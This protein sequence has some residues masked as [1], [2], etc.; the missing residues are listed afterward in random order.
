MTSHEHLLNSTLKSEL[1][2]Y[3]TKRSAGPAAFTFTD[4]TTGD[5]GSLFAL[6]HADSKAPS[7]TAI[8]VVP[9]SGLTQD[10]QMQLNDVMMLTSFISVAS[11]RQLYNTIYKSAP[12]DITT[13]AG[14]ALFVQSAANAKTFVLTKALGGYLSL[15]TSA[16]RAFSQ[17]TTSADLHLDFLNTLFNG[18]NFPKSTIDELDGVLT[19]VTQTIGNL[20]MSWSDQSS[21]LDHMIFLYYFDQVLG[22]DVKIPKV[23]LYFLHIDQAS[24]S[25]SI[26]KSSVTHFQFN[27]NFIDSVYDMDVQQTAADRENIKGLLHT[28]TGHDLDELNK[29]LSPKAVKDASA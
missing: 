6:L 1:L 24:W 20:K 4:T 3:S 29:L 11:M 9:A 27:M 2:A 23:R 12:P 26:G 10:M 5:Q 21:T 17:S 28:L 16:A 15:N 8:A 25:A 18:F 14:A 19:S 7:S 13:P 22:I